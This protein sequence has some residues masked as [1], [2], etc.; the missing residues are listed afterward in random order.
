M[1]AHCRRET[2]GSEGRGEG[3]GSCSQFC[4]SREGVRSDWGRRRPSCKTG[5]ATSEVLLPVFTSLQGQGISHETRI[6]PRRSDLLLTCSPK[7]ACLPFPHSGER[8]LLPAGDQ[9]LH[10]SLKTSCHIGLFYCDFIISHQ[11]V[12]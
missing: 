12:L 2:C 6:A 4:L 11:N 8:P 10:E 7:P 9:V 1:G 5:E 3:W